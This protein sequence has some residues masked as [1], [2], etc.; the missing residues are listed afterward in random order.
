[1][2]I[3][4]IARYTASKP[5]EWVMNPTGTGSQHSHCVHAKCIES[6]GVHELLLANKVG[7][8]CLA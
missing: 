3:A 8:H 5:H 2:Y 7:Y 6:Y 4:V 1:M